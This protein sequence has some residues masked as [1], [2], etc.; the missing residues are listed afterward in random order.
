MSAGVA[1]MLGVVPR[2]GRL[3]TPAE[4]LPGTERVVML[5][6]ALWRRRFGGDPRILGRAITL[7]EQPYTVIGII[8]RGRRSTV[9]TALAAAQELDL[10]MNLR[11]DAKKNATR[12]LQ[13]LDM[14]GRLRPGLGL[15]QAAERTVSF[16]RG[17][18]E[19]V[20]TDQDVTLLPLERLVIGTARP[21]LIALAGA[22]AMVLLIA[23]TNVANLLLARAAG[24]RCGVAHRGGR[25]GAAARDREPGG[26]RL[27]ARTPRAAVAGREPAAGAARRRRR[28]AR[29]LGRRGGGGRAPPAQRAP[30]R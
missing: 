1:R 20:G 26:A 27:G 6:E 17:L 23:C 22:V 3:F 30:G 13:F 24:R 7:G 16:A 11:L 12:D 21:L 4:D 25:G 28:Y 14:L 19:A 10:W 2:V 9:P 5:S 18:K 8:P 29:G 15:A